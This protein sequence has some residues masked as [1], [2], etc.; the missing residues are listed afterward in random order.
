MRVLTMSALAIGL[1]AVPGAAFAQPA[2][3]T[4]PP[5]S[6]RAAPPPPTIPPTPRPFSATTAPR[7]VVFQTQGLTCG[8]GE[9]TPLAPLDVA[10]QPVSILTAYGV[11]T[12][13]NPDVPSPAPP[14]VVDPVFDYS[15]NVSADGR[16]LDL[17]VITPPSAAFLQRQPYIADQEVQPGLAAWRFAPG[18]PATGCRVHVVGR[19]LSYDLAGRTE[20]ARAFALNPTLATGA[21]EIRAAL[22]P[23]ADCYAGEPLYPR[24]QHFAPVDEIA[25]APGERSWTVVRFDVAADGRTRDV[26]VVASSGRPELAAAAMRAQAQST[27]APHAKRG[28]LLRYST[29]PG[30]LQA[31]PEPPTVVAENGGCPVN[32]KLALGGIPVSFP[33]SFSRRRIEGYALLSYDVAPWGQVGEVK[34]IKSE[35]AA[36]FGQQARTMIQSSRVAPSDRGYQGCQKPFRFRISEEQSVDEVRGQ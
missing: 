28:C 30:L 16:V 32:P 5:A 14:S 19:V 24:V 20:I 17:A 6:P 35:P 2:A 36:A 34:V 10:P 15:F 26:R 23:G 7:L 31:P 9:P 21:R 25:E 27:Y 8:G 4:A 1:L 33:P 3:A 29:R 18:Q 22:E 12:F 11:P 13:S